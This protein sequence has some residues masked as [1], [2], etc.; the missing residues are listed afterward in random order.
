MARAE[1]S[2]T[3]AYLHDSPNVPVFQRFPRTVARNQGMATLRRMGGSRPHFT[4][5]THDFYVRRV[6]GRNV[7]RRHDKGVMP[8]QG[9]AGRKAL[10][11]GLAFANLPRDSCLATER[12]RPWRGQPR[13]SLKSASDSR[14]TATC[15]PSS[16]PPNVATTPLNGASHRYRARFGG[17]GC[18][19]AMELPLPGLRAGVG[20]R[21]ARAPAHPG[22]HCRFG[23]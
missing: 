1:Q 21:Q 23:G 11:A 17:R 19:S 9:A 7:G 5:Y 12:K 20:R 2:A 14:L 18:I 22:R 8:P 13:S 4:G 15:R 6:Y 3:V 10:A 16:D